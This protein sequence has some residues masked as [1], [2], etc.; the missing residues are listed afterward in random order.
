MEPRPNTGRA[1]DGQWFRHA[2]QRARVEFFAAGGRP[3]QF[4]RLDVEDRALRQVVSAPVGVESR[5]E[6]YRAIRRLTREAR[7][8]LRDGRFEQFVAALEG[9]QPRPKS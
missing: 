4:D 1:R 8:A 3:E 7:Q 6:V 9:G 2:V 5:A